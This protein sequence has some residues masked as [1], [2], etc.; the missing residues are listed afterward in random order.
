[1]AC[2]CHVCG[3]EQHGADGLPSCGHGLPRLKPRPAVCPT[4]NGHGIVW[5]LGS[6]LSVADA[7]AYTGPVA[8]PVMG[9]PK[10]QIACPDCRGGK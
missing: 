7:Q 3:D 5:A 6:R 10:V 2:P 1:M 8:W 4:C 9:G